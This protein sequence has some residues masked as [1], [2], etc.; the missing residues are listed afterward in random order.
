MKS[1]ISKQKQKKLN[2]KCTSISIKISL[3]LNFASHA[4]FVTKELTTAI[5]FVLNCVT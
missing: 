4:N 1:L 3:E 5:M 2:I